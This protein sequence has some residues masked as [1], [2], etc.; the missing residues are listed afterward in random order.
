MTF[1]CSRRPLLALLLPVICAAALASDYGKVTADKIADGVYQFSVSG[2]GDVGMS[3]NSVAIIGDDG[4]L[5]FDTT[6]TPSSA[7]FILAD[8]K[9]I[10]KRPVRYVVNSHWHWD[11]WG[12]NEVFGSAFPNVQIISQEKTRAMMMRD[13]VDWN[14]DYLAT[15]IPK[16]IDEVA[17]AAKKA[18]LPPI[19]LAFLN[20]PELIA[21]SFERSAH[22]PILSLT[23]SSLIQ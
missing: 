3:G 10:T 23:R 13:A 14:R 2:Y 9:K 18:V 17:A 19:A 5:I 8:L 21:R 11:H 7:R 1:V 16:H 20:W 6:G 12:G 4:V 22:W 15:I